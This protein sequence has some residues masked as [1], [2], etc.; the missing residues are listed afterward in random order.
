MLLEPAGGGVVRTPSGR[1]LRLQDP[2]PGLAAALAGGRVDDAAAAEYADLLTAELVARE[3]RD[4]DRR[5]PAARRDVCL[6]GAGETVDALA[7]A[8]SGWGIEPVAGGP[9][10]LAAP[11]RLVIAVAETPRE[12]AHWGE[13]DTLPARG[14]AWLRGYREG[15]TCF[16]DPLAVT[17]GDP[18]SEQVRRR[19]LAASSVPRELA[20]WQRAVASAPAPLPVAARTLLLARVL[21]V[22]LAWAQDAPALDAFRRTLWKLV[23]PSMTITEHP[24]LGYDE[25]PAGRR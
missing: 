24:V 16:V 17:T 4:A 5:W 13:L 19:R 23:A 15:E 12:R 8:L 2:P 21:T 1:F 11:P 9:D 22:A 6:V 25:P 20:V 18:G 10:G 7:E 14:I 3:G